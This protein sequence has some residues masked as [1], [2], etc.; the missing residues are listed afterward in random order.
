MIKIVLFSFLTVGG[1][2]A[3]AIFSID[4]YDLCLSLARDLYSVLLFAYRYT[5]NRSANAPS[6][7]F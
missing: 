4:D 2:V 7:G 5:L 1:G 3:H 6:G